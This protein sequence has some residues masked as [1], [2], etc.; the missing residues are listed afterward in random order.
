MKNKK[1]ITLICAAIMALG[2]GGV[3]TACDV[4]DNGKTTA[5]VRFN[6]NTQSETNS[7]KDKTV[8][9]GKRVTQPKAYILEENPDNF[10]FFFLM[11][12]PLFHFLFLHLL[13]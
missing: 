1:L 5:T 7:V 4:K 3:A 2:L 6:V 12:L 11:L 10:Q 9:I 13:L 8:T